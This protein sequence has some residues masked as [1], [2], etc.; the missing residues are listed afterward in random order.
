M[1]SLMCWLSEP[2]PALPF[3]RMM[4]PL[5]MPASPT[6]L[7]V[8]AAL[9]RMDTG[10]YG[11]IG[12]DGIYGRSGLEQGEAFVCWEMKAFVSGW[13]ACQDNLE[14]DAMNAA[15]EAEWRRVEAL[16]PPDEPTGAAP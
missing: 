11:I 10:G 9:I 2:S 6:R 15:L 7:Q 8:L 1:R 13:L 3:D 16:A 5:G 14:R 12:G 4:P